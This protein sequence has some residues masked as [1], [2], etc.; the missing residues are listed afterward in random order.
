MPKS[1]SLSKPRW[2]TKMFSGLI[3]LWIT[4]CWWIQSSA[5]DICAR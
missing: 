1:P 3:S 4:S 2:S 5:R